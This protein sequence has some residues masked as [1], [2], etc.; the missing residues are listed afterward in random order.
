MSTRSDRDTRK[1]RLAEAVWQVVRE[2]GIGAVSV[3]SVAREAGV[4]VGSL[5]HLFPSRAELVEFSAELMVTR[6]TDRIRRIP[7]HG[8]VQH[9]ALEVV[10]ELLPL[11][12]DSRAELEV[13]IALIAESPAVPGLILLRDRAHQELAAACTQLVQ[14][15][16]DSPGDEQSIA[17]GQRLHALIDGLA[18]HLLMRP[19]SVDHT[20]ALDIVRRELAQIAS[21]RGPGEH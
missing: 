12:P 7:A 20:W 9:Y 18:I 4:A 3:R 21:R 13:N 19:A 6:V 8:D 5:R 10:R 17:Q 15:L 14:L 16:A 1:A 11:E 2:Q